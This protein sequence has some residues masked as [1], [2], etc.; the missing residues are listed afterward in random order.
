VT[1]TGAG[2]ESTDGAGTGKPAGGATRGAQR[3]DQPAAR[4]K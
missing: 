1:F 4:A 3:G 2:A